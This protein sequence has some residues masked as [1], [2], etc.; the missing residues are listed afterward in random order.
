MNA[1]RNSLS[2]PVDT[3]WKQVKEL[4]R[5]KMGNKVAFYNL[6]TPFQYNPNN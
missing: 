5:K 6:F 3:L 1:L 4:K 2:K